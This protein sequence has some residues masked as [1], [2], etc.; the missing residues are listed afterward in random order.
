[1]HIKDF[2][3]HLSP[4][5]IAQ[6]AVEPRDQSRLMVLTARYEYH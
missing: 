4:E 5:L 1:M 3:Y 6:T 2:D